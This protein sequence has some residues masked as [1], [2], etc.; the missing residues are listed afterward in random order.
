MRREMALTFTS[1]CGRQCELHAGADSRIDTFTVQTRGRFRVDEIDALLLAVGLIAHPHGRAALAAEVATFDEAGDNHGW[2]SYRSAA[3]APTDADMALGISWR[4]TVPY[5]DTVIA[6]IE[7]LWRHPR[8]RRL[9]VPSPRPEREPIN[10]GETP[11]LVGETTVVWMHDGTFSASVIEHILKPRTWTEGGIEL[12]S[13]AEVEVVENVMKA[14]VAGDRSVL[15][16]IGAYDD[17][18]D[19]YLW[20]RDYGRFGEVHLFCRQEKLA[21][22]ERACSRSTTSQGCPNS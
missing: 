17:G 14:L 9:D 3:V 18:T 21:T 6:E 1:A 12:L 5:R 16:D 10:V 20:T 7:N 11:L 19:P 4:F 8:G 22:G 13:T 15:V 2:P